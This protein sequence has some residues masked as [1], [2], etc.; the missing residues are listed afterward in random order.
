[1]YVLARYEHQEAL[2]LQGSSSAGESNLTGGSRENGIPDD[3]LTLAPPST[4]S[5]WL[6]PKSTDPLPASASNNQNFFRDHESHHFHQVG[7][8]GIVLLLSSAFPIFWGVYLI[9]H[10]LWSIKGS[11]QG[12]RQLPERIYRRCSA[13]SILLQLPASCK[14]TRYPGGD[15]FQNLQWRRSRIYRSWVETVRWLNRM[16]HLSPL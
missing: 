2:S 12:I 14:S 7:Q 11:C 5:K 4:S 1:M 8:P 16:K 9:L 3:F 13:T 6:N 15:G 10:F